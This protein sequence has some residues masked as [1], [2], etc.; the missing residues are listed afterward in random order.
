MGK[1]SVAGRKRW[2][3]GIWKRTLLGGQRENSMVGSW[4]LVGWVKD[5]CFN[6]KS[7]KT[8][9]TFQNRSSGV[10]IE[11]GWLE[12][13]HWAQD[14][15]NCIALIIPELRVGCGGKSACA[16]QGHDTQNASLS[17]TASCVWATMLSGEMDSFYID[18][19][20][21]GRNRWGNRAYKSVK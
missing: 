12:G 13:A 1:R 7:R 16:L 6:L 21:K 10:N 5:Y 18:S 11:N 20:F 4:D 14:Q 3:S 8:R 17:A 9:L 19:H 15:D 2:H